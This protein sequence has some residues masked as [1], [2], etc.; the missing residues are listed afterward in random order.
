M[1][2][3]KLL[4]AIATL[5]IAF[6][7]FAQVK[8]GDNPTTINAGSVLELEST[9]KGLLLPRI[10]LTNTTTWQLMGTPVAGMHVY[11]TN[12]AITAGNFNYPI[13]AAKIGEYYWDGA[14]WVALAKT[15]NC[16][17]FDSSLGGG[18]TVPIYDA[19]GNPA[20]ILIATTE[21]YDPANAYNPATGEYTVPVAGLYTFKGTAGDNIAGII[22]ATRNSTISIVRNRGGV[23]TQLAF[24]VVQGQVYNNGSWNNISSLNY[25][26]AGDI[27]TFRV[28]V[29]HAS[30]TKPAASIAVSGINFSGSR[31]DC[32]NN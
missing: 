14:G 26:L 17:S 24:S 28:N 27:I 31:T 29:V 10:A 5:G 16:A 18:Q 32:T 8:I 6:S 19:N 1:K 25:L 2:T 23:L 11:N 30:G 13:L 21:L 20:A 3:T 4:L 22:N 7:S 12:A 15:V 9:N